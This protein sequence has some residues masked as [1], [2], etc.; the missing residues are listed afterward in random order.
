M[1]FNEA[2]AQ[3]RGIL[4]AQ[5]HGGG[6]LASMRPLHKAGEYNRKLQGSA[7]DAMLQ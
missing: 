1:R 7:A 2:P 5:E 4:N 3:G 6:D